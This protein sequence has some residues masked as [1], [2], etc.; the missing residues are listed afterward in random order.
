MR[1]KLLTASDREMFGL[2]IP[3]LGALI[4]E[5]LY[6]LADTAVV[7]NIGTPEL[8]GLGLA[9]Q[10]IGTVLA[11]SLFLAYGTTSTVSRLLGAGRDRDAAH[12][13]VQGLWVA[14]GVGV[15]FG[16][17]CF[18][19]APQLMRLLQADPDVEQFGVR[20]LRVSVF[21]FPAM[22]LVMAGVGYLRGL[23]DTRRPLI[24]ALVT[25]IGNLV[26]ELILVFGFGFGVGASALSTVIFQWVAAGLYLRWIGAAAREHEVGGRP[27][28]QTLRALGRDGFD[29]FLRTSALRASLIVAAAIAASIGTPELGAHE[30]GMAWFGFLALALDAIAIAGQAMVG[31]LLGAKKVAEATALG[32]RLTAWGLVLGVGATVLLLP[33]RTLLPEI[34][35]DDAAVI[36]HATD[37][38]LLLAVMQPLAGV[39]FALDGVLIGAGDMRFLARAM[40]LSTTVFLAAASVVVLLDGGILALW[41]AIIIF[42]AARC[43]PLL[44]R[45]RGEEWAVAGDRRTR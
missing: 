25:A 36:G 34:F 41:V 43:V 17:I 5:P 10:V 37:V 20:Y 1:A 8:G 28:P 18:A 2:A 24:V 44:L 12:Q 22:L 27:D 19:L 31:T 21:G 39:A 9:T 45:I 35:T 13:A 30:I 15:V 4:A 16:V 33:F 6:V 11:I 7:G 29:L 40:M 38:L 14:V 26:L 42:T 32:R 3:A 23:K